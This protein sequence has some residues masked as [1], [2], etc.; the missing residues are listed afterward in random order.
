MSINTTITIANV[1]G[2]SPSI[3]AYFVALVMMMLIATAVKTALEIVLIKLQINIFF[4][5]FVHDNNILQRSLLF[6]RITQNSFSFLF[7]V[8][9]ISFASYPT[10][11]MTSYT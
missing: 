11:I 2:N 4:F 8:F 5:Y 3:K 6:F 9:N 1:N 10:S 7:C